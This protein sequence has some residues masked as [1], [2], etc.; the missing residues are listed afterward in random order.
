MHQ[1]DLSHRHHDHRRHDNDAW[2]GSKVWFWESLLQCRLL[3][4]K[5]VVEK[6]NQLL[7]IVIMIF[8]T[9]I[10][11]HNQLLII[12][13]MIIVIIIIIITFFGERLYF[14]HT[15]NQA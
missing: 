7:I 15:T 12:V 4:R 14:D 5:P 6:A 3:P 10:N 8:V 13:V 11:H 1:H 9:I 2:K